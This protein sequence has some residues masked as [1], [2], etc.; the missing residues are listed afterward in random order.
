MTLKKFLYLYIL[1]GYTIVSA[2]HKIA[3]KANLNAEKKIITIQQTIEY[4]NTSSDTLSEL[5][6]HDWANAFSAKT[7]ELGK[8]FSEDF[9]KRFY[10]AKDDERGRTVIQTFL[11]S[12]NVV[13]WNRY[14]DNADIRWR[15][16]LE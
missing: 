7:T 6:F 9:L 1:I 10:Y 14:K 8:R 13:N 4:H 11:A 5:F 3:I 15:S 16:R 2:Q 12:N